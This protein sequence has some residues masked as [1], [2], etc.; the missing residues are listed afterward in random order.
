MVLLSSSSSFEWCCFL[1]LSGGA[2]WPPPFVGRAAFLPVLWVVLV[3]A[4]N[5][6]LRLAAVIETATSTNLGAIDDEDRATAKL[7]VQQAV[8]AAEEAW[9]QPIGE[10]QEPSVKKPI[11]SDLKQPSSAAQDVD[12]EEVDSKEPTQCA[13][14]PSA[15]ALDSGVRRQ[16]V[17]R[18]E[19][20]CH[21]HV[22]H[23]WLYHLGACAGSVL[24]PHN[25]VTNVQKRLGNRAWTGFGERRMCG[26]FLDPQLEHQ[27]TCSTAEATRGAHAC[28]PWHAD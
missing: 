20:L 7:Y 2:A 23:K 5:Q 9:Q 12:G 16:Q 1:L 25:Y 11:V 21:T 27:E 22:F 28:T 6:P 4:P 13:A 19:D 17:T 14:A 10:L 24:T 26:S 8:Q 15:V 3:T 18:I